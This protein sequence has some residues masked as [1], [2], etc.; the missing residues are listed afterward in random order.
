MSSYSK[1]TDYQQKLRELK[2]K[3]IDATLRTDLEK[4]D[5]QL[6]IDKIELLIKTQ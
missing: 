3:L 2:A 6:E 5:W 4:K 1:I